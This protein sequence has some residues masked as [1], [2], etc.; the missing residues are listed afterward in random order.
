MS[1]HEAKGPARTSLSDIA[2]AAGVQRNTLYRH[3]PD[4]RS[5]LLACSGLHA[6]RNPAPDPAPWREIGDPVER[7]RTGLSEVYE[8]FEANRAML[9]NVMRDAE[10]HPIVREVAELR[11]GRR[12]GETV[13]VLGEGLPERPRV[14]ATLAL[15]LDFRT[16]RRLADAGLTKDQAVEAMV[17]AVLAQ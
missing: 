12:G 17:A 13:A 5:I 2:R 14:R 8:Y 15:A 11:R 7:L 10:V 6:E 16:W 4:E 9:S 3:F 1:L